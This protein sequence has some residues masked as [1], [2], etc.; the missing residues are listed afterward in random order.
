MD[1]K[2]NNIIKFN[3]KL[4]KCIKSP[5][6]RHACTKCAF[7][8]ENCTN[9]KNIIGECSSDYRS[10]KTS[11]IFEEIKENVDTKLNT[12][13]E[14]FNIDK[15]E[16]GEPVCTKEGKRV[17][18][19]CFDIINELPIVAAI[20]D[21]ASDGKLKETVKSYY[22]DGKISKNADSPYDLIMKPKEIKEGFSF[23]PKNANIIL[24]FEIAKKL[25]PENCKI[26]R[27]QLI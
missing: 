3:D 6:D 27:I 1:V 4:Y 9:I 20:S 22:I 11:I 16:L 24:D 25:C 19:L 26:V 5:I 23:M 17:R 7:L 12:F 2:V 10:D 21:V 14:P 15:A 8:K 18:I 13:I